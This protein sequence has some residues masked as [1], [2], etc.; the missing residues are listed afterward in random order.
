MHSG[1]T[2]PHWSF[3]RVH[4]E[5]IF[6]TGNPELGVITIKLGEVHFWEMTKLGS[7]NWLEGTWLRWGD[8]HMLY[9]LDRGLVI[10][11]GRRMVVER[12]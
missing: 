5:I 3:D 12:G 4:L 11:N 2:N 8:L 1:N 9:W 6:G 7:G 10:G